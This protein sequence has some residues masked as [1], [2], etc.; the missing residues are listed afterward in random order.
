MPMLKIRCVKC[1][2]MIPTGLDVDFETFDSL[3]YTERT[4]ECSNCEAVQI[5]TLDDVDRRP[6][7]H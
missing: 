2:W 4:A 3:T 7:L 1:A 5:W 6:R